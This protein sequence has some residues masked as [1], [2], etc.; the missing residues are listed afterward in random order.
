MSVKNWTAGEE[1]LAHDLNDMGTFNGTAG[2]AI[3]STPQAVYI[4]TD[5]KFYKLAGTPISKTILAGFSIDKAGG[6][7]SPIGI[8]THGVVKEFSGLSINEKYYI[9][10]NSSI[11]TPIGTMETLVGI[12]VSATELLIT[13]GNFEYL[14]SESYAAGGFLA[15][16]QARHAVINASASGAKG[17]VSGDIFLSRNGKTSGNIYGLTAPDD[18]GASHQYIGANASWNT[19]GTPIT[20]TV[21]GGA[22]SVDGTAYYYR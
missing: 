13:K 2:E 19:S 17:S 12:A 9:Q 20:L 21:S 11:G 22:T 6:S 3:T 8:Q 7:G 1:I 18:Q 16:S 15:P 4:S 5:G 10:D 14:Y